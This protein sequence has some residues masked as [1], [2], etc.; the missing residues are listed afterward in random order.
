M[1]IVLETCDYE[2]IARE[3]A[4]G[5]ANG[6]G[7]FLY[8]DLEMEVEYYVDSSMEYDNDYFNGTGSWIVKSTRV[9]VDNITCGDIEVE[10]DN[11]KIERLAE[12]L[13]MQ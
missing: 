3:I 11:Y 13:I 12:K 6:K 1:R 8:S 5:S 10:Y 4:Q 2:D 9:S 7:N